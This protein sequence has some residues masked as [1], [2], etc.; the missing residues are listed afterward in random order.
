MYTF[1]FIQKMLILYINLYDINLYMLDYLSLILSW[2]DNICILFIIY[3]SS[4]L[5]VKI[6]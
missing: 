5:I 3:L 2:F 1:Y 6:Y 4:K